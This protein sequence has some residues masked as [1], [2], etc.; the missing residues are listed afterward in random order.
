RLA[1]VARALHAIDH[2]GVI[3]LHTRVPVADAARVTDDL[4]AALRGRAAVYVLLHCNHPRELTPAAR[5]AC[6]R[7]IDAGIPMLSQTVLLPG[8][9]EDVETMAALMRALVA[10]RIKPHY[11]HHGDLAP[12]TRGFRTTIAHGQRVMRALRGAVSGLCQPTYV[13]DIPGG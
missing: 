9:N 10:A 1:E 4:I 13:L 12:G 6:A 7:L 11:L 5:A 2:V 8:V 3:R